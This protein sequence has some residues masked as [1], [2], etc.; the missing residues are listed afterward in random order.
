MVHH[1]NIGADWWGGG[2]DCSANKSYTQYL[3]GAPWTTGK[4]SQG[5]REKEIESH[6]EA[7]PSFRAAENGERL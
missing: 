4:V 2:S 5:V 3:L 7:A 1:D 6:N